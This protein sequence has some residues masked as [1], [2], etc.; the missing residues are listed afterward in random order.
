M[1]YKEIQKKADCF[2]HAVC[3]GWHWNWNW[4]D[5]IVLDSICH[6]S[7]YIQ[8]M[9]I[10]AI[11]EWFLYQRFLENGESVN[12]K[13]VDLE[14]EFLSMSSIVYSPSLVSSLAVWKFSTLF[15]D[16]IR[17]FWMYG[18]NFVWTESSN[19]KDSNEQNVTSNFLS[20]DSG[21]FF[22]DNR[23]VQSRFVIEIRNISLMKQKKLYNSFLMIVAHLK[24][25]WALNCSGKSISCLQSTLYLNCHSIENQ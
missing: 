16:Y 8:R 25:L 23:P 1:R 15:L 7:F 9:E 11:A 14:N 13:L 3:L 24:C 10:W 19:I 18:F 2:S 12:V 21:I 22:C 17:S 5:M 4:N 20:N 6:F